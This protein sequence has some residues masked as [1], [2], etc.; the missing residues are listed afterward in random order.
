MVRLW[1]P[2]SLARS[3]RYQRAQP[4][5]LSDISCCSVSHSRSVR[6]RHSGARAT[7]EKPEEADGAETFLCA[8]R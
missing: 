2:S 6:D 4:E 8:G 7:R 5:N 1:V 3:A